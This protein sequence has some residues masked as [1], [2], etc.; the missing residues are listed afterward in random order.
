MLVCEVREVCEVC[1]GGL[2]E[3]PVRPVVFLLVFYA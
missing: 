3:S 1:E 2:C